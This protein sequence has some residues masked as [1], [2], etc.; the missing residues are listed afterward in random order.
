MPLE[1]YYLP[2]IKIS[3]SQIN[4]L[5]FVVEWEK[6]AIKRKKKMHLIGFEL[7]SSLRGN[8]EEQNYFM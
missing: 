3:L 2:L 8:K 6:V 7:G 1:L 5:F 4:E